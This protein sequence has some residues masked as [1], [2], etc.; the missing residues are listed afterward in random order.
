M[1]KKRIVAIVPMRKGSQRVLNK[2]LRLLD[3][4][5]L[6]EYLLDVLQDVTEVSRIIIDTDI[7]KVHAF[8]RNSPKIITRGRNPRF[9]DNCDVNLVISDILREVSADVFIQLH[10][11]SPLLRPETISEAIRT[12]FNYGQEIDCLFGVTRLKKRF[13]TGKVHPI[14]HKVGDVPTTQDVTPVFE[15]NSALYIFWSESFR[16]SGH[17][18]GRRQAFFEVPPEEAWDIDEEYELGIVEYLLRQRKK[19]IY[20]A[21]APG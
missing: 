12:F 10:V 13:W 7:E 2:N 20:Q 11:T 3:G 1:S 18:L 5:H 19:T 16:K 17:R 8:Y 21:E 6:F 9:K 4:R 14:N 15:E